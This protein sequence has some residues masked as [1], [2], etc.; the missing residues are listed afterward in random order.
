[1]GLVA[2]LEIGISTDLVEAESIRIR[3]YLL[4]IVSLQ[5]P[6]IF[7]F[8]LENKDERAGEKFYLI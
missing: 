1:M 5:N 4:N 3:A 7:A 8:V 6:R 2:F